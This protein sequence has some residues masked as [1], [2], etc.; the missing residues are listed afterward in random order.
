M[1]PQSCNRLAGLAVVLAL[2]VSACNP[3]AGN[4]ESFVTIDSAGIAIAD[5][6]EPEWRVGGAWSLAARPDLSIGQAEGDSTQQL[7]QVAAAARIAADTVIVVNAG[8][9]EVRWYDRAGRFIRSVGRQGGGPGEFS[10]FGPGNLCIVSDSEI[11]VSDPGQQ[12]ANVFT[13]AGEFVAVVQ[14]AA[15]AAFPSIQGCFADGSLLAWRS[16]GSSDRIPGTIIQS[17]F[18]WSRLSANG[19][20]LADLVELPS[21]PQYLLDQGDGTATYHTIPFTT[22]PTAAASSEY[23]YAAPGGPPVIE[24]RALTGTLDMLIRWEPETRVQSADVY[25]RYR[26]YTIDAQSSAQRR[27]YWTRF[28]EL[29]LDTPDEIAAVSALQVDDAGYVWAE[30]YRLPWDSAATWD[31]FAPNGRWLGGVALPRE[32]RPL[33]MGNDFILGVSRDQLG[34]ERVD[35]YHLQREGS[36]R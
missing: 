31:V 18:I 20:R 8:T 17:Q 32:F 24:C 28:F 12:R 7:Y 29:G 33:H 11:L 1:T 16:V 26:A 2:G 21:S 13:R 27:T 9:A 6:R 19:E 36:S 35:S 10:R 22:R 25:D 14:L 23:L 4:P 3:S 5:N 30:R 34:V 15:D